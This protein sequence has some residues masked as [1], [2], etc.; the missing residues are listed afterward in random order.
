MQDTSLFIGILV[1]MS[2][3]NFVLSWFEHEKPRGLVLLRQLRFNK[4]VKTILFTTVF[5]LVTIVRRFEEVWS[6]KIVWPWLRS[7]NV[8]MSSVIFVPTES[9][10][11]VILCLQLSSFNWRVNFTWANAN[12]YITCVCILS[13]GLQDSTWLQ[14]RVVT[15][16]LP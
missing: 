3:W 10:S 13:C 12:R 7:V 11:D 9:D 15:C 6:I 2:S 16:S 8:D 1:F 5:T 4:W 14:N